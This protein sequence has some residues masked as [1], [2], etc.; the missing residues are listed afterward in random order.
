MGEQFRFVGRPSV[1][2]KSM[3]S[4]LVLS[5]DCVSPSSSWPF[6]QFGLEG[7]GSCASLL[8]PPG[9]CLPCPEMLYKILIWL[10][11][12]TAFYSFIVLSMG[13]REEV[14]P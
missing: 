7:E 6:G 5:E 13:N 11:S 8:P 3:R 1:D 4:L 10:M 14:L 2:Q 12:F 9:S